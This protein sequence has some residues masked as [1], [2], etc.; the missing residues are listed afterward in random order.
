MAKFLDCKINFDKR[1]RDINLG[2]YHGRLKKEFYNDFPDPIKR[3]S[4]GP[5]KGE[6]W[7]DLKK[8]VKSFLKEIEKKYKNKRILIVS[9][10]DTLW[11]LEGIL[12]K[13]M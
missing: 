1:L 6:S 5:K 11:M 10:G 4:N 2:I 8:R 13:F 3:F 7:N 12:K 9:H